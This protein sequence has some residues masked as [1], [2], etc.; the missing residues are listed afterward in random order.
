MLTFLTFFIRNN[1]IRCRFNNF[2]DTYAYEYDAIDD[3]DLTIY[4][5][6][7]KGSI[8]TIVMLTFL[9]YLM[10]NKRIRCRL[11]NYNR[12]YAYEYDAIDD[13]DLTIYSVD[14]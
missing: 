13:Y 3:D 1:T 5:V 10:R 6:D 7:K 9:T 14:K 11:N 4:I 2:N 12:P 8:F